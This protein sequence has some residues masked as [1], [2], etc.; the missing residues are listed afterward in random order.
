M[1]MKELTANKR[2]ETI[3]LKMHQESSNPIFPL[4]TTTLFVLD[5]SSQSFAS[6]IVAPK[7]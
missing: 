6:P 2:V 4:N 7:T 1:M 5:E 3:T